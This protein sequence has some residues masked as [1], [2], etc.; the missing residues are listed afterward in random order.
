[1]F[2]R[3]NCA[4][5][6]RL[7]TEVRLLCRPRMRKIDFVLMQK[8]T[9]TWSLLLFKMNGS[10][11]TKMVAC[12]TLRYSTY[13]YSPRRVCQNVFGRNVGSTRRPWTTGKTRVG[14]WNPKWY[15]ARTRLA[16]IRLRHTRSRINETLGVCVTVRRVQVP[17]MCCLENM[18]TGSVGIRLRASEPNAEDEKFQH[19]TRERSWKL[20]HQPVEKFNRR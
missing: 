1:M 8:S 4:S 13:H 14:N 16:W 17:T 12:E 10:C 5:T 3:T 18:R 7:H 11:A 20:A 9:L 6:T 19:R 2:L 15:N